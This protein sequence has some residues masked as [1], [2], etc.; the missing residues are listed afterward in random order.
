[1]WVSATSPYNKVFRVDNA[2]HVVTTAVGGDFAESGDFGDGGPG[3]R[4]LVDNP[5]GI[6]IGPDR[7]VWISDTGN[8]RLR[9]LD[10]RT[11]IITS[12]TGKLPMTAPG[13]IQITAT[14]TFLIT[15]LDDGSVTEFRP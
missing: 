3:A 6:A 1:M 12:W 11:G 2:S 9:I 7:N 14:G 15:S 10:P 8:D 5:S 4:A 13:P